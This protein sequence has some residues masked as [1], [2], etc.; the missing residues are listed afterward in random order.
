MRTIFLVM[1]SLN[2]HFLDSY[3]GGGKAIT[4]NIDRLANRAVVFDNHWCG[5]MPCMPARR[6]MMTGRLNFLET[7]WSPIMPWDVCLPPLLRQEKQVYSHMITDHYHYFHSGGE[8]YHTLFDSWELER[9]QEG[10]A[11]RPLVQ[12]PDVP[13]GRGKGT[14]REAYWRN[15]HF[16]DPEDDLS[17]PTPRCFQR[18]VDFLELNRDSDNWHLH[19]EVFDP[20][21]PFDCPKQYRDLYN[22]TWQRYWYNWP[23]YSRLDPEQDDPEA[24]EHIRKCYAATL[25]MADHW[26]GKFLDKMDERGLWDDTVLIVTTDHGHLLGEHGYWAKNYQFDY[27]ELAHIPLLICAPGMAP[28]R[29]E[30]M[31]ATM[32]LMPTILDCHGVKTPE[33]AHGVSL[34]PLLKNGESVRTET[35]FGY[36]SKDVNYTDGRY[37]Y[38]RQPL[39][40][41]TVHHYSYMPRGFQ[42]YYSK[43]M[44][45][46]GVAGV[47]LPSQQGI[48]CWRFEQPSTPHRDAKDFHE[49]Y[50]LAKD[51]EQNTPLH[52]AALEQQLAGRLKTLLKQYEAPECQYPRLGF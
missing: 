5:S 44:L 45:K 43:D 14:V 15:R 19:L 50:D 17:Y 31:S 37:T 23:E 47:F 7:P 40:G 27:R 22:D 1:D 30:G 12:R 10:D 52:D 49:L 41:S 9:G 51:P 4:P 8:C 21:E 46:T 42:D 35:I 3:G 16:L 36:F 24:V 29:R 2:R 34:L 11:W 26:L 33:S 6:E 38:C 18:A 32:D 28:G 13:K 25:T 48:P 39:E 20:H